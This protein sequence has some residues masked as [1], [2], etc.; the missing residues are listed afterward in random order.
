MDEESILVAM[1]TSKL[2]ELF[3]MCL[4]FLFL[5]IISGRK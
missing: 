2:L 1:I 5:A 4:L 3:A